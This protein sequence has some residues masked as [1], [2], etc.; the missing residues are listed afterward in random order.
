MLSELNYTLRIVRKYPLPNGVIVFTIA[1][2]VAV[3]GLM[4]A[5]F[6]MNSG[7]QMPFEDPDSFVRFWRTTKNVKHQHI[8]SDIYHAY[9]EQLTSYSKIGAMENW[10]RFTLTGAG[11]ATTLTAVK[12]TAE[13][14]EMTGMKPVQG[15]FFS[16]V[17][18]DPGNREIVVLNETAWEV[19]FDSDPDI[20]GKSIELNDKP[21]VVVGIAPEALHMTHLAWGADMWMPRNW[22]K[23]TD[24]NPKTINIVARLKPGKTLE[25]AQAELSVLAPRIEEGRPKFENETRW[26]GT[27]PDETWSARVIPLDEHLN[28][29]Q[30][31]SRQIFAMVFAFT[32][33]TYRRCIN[34]KNELRKVETKHIARFWNNGEGQSWLD[35]EFAK[36]VQFDHPLG[37][38]QK[39]K[40]PFPV[41]EKP[42]S[43]AL[44]VLNALSIYDADLRQLADALDRPNARF[45][46]VFDVF[47]LTPALLSR[48]ER[49]TIEGALIQ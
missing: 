7:R 5:S 3:I 36:R 44:D 15:R 6:R 27:G 8:P 25:E 26:A 11:E 9:K 14:L 31:D 21:Y 12:C 2:L 43:A 32:E 23:K 42:Q 1:C 34:G 19:H 35:E 48:W 39:N 10:A 24:E 40:K 28:S 49:E 33:Y 20:L 29:R 16:K 22:P 4:F 45:Q 46:T 18:E 30:M 41:S 47:S 13:V 38:L 17:D 37:F